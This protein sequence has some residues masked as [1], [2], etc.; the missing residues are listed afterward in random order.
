MGPGV[1]PYPTGTRIGALSSVGRERLPYK[2]EVAG[3]NPAAPIEAPKVY[4][5]KPMSATLFSLSTRAK[6][7][8]RLDQ[9]ALRRLWSSRPPRPELGLDE[10][11]LREY[12]GVYRLV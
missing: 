3:S 1:L 7:H 12:V 5:Q 2:Q 6:I 9:L 4:R 8:A 10:E 11:L